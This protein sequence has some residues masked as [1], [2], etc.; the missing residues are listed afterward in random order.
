MSTA[1]LNW[2]VPTTRVDGT[3]LA[4]SDVAS[5][6][7]FDSASPT[8]NMAIGTVQ[9]AGTSFATGVLS[10][11]VHNF[12]VVVNDTTGHSSATSN[13]ASANI[14]AVLAAPSA[15]TTLAVTVNP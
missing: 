6:D 4:P 13:V 11:G 3:A 12:T 5:I 2:T 14:P 9:G 15:V 8:P 1:T 7:V 10:V